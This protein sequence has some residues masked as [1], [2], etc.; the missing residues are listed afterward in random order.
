MTF[1]L[2][3]QNSGALPGG[4]G[5]VEMVGGALTIGRGEENDLT[6]PDPERM[7]SKRHC[8]IEDHGG[9]Y[10]VVDIS[11]NGT[12]LNYGPERLG[13]LPTPLNHGDVLQIG[14]Y[15]LVAEIASG[16]AAASA[17]P[18][19]GIAPPLEDGPVSH[20]QAV[21]HR[22]QHDFVGTLDDPA[23]KDGSDFLDGL[24]GS[25]DGAQASAGASSRQSWEQAVIPE[26]PLEA[27]A[28]LPDQEDPFFQKPEQDPFG[29]RGASEQDHSQSTADF[30]NKPKA[31]AELIP[32]DWDDLMAP[33]TPV[34]PA[35]P[36]A[37]LETG[38]PFAASS[39][40]ET[41]MADGPFAEKAPAEP[42]PSIAAPASA[43]EPVAPPTPDPVPMHVAP[44]TPAKP[45]PAPAANV[46]LVRTFL[47]EAGAGQL[48]IPDEELP[49]VMA[50]MG[51]V[52]GAMVTGMREI[53]ITRA[54]IKGELRMNRT[55]I[56]SAGN[57]PLKF[58]ISPEQAIEAMVRPST[59]GY[60]DAETATAEALRDIKAHEVAMM[61]GME[62]A[63]K[64]LLSRL[65][66]E[67]LTERI[68][69]GSSLGGLLGGKKA[70]YWEAYASMYSEIAKEAED[71][72][73]SAFGREFARA[74]EEQ[75]KKL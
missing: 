45:A 58:T 29:P 17:D 61:S 69:T 59:S 43:P 5:S 19:A 72:F 71:D 51:A 13:D 67:K 28:P 75:L 49:K 48:N 27:S 33:E 47:E 16:E 10:V 3:F 9:N 36:T 53:L 25:G 64:D 38:D 30:Y 68:E 14:N 37:Q 20:G 46:D 55:M 12:F 24:L 73:Q 39:V 1:R 32:D 15:E 54:S 63:L 18:L 40:G 31:Q 7:L 44:P 34:A 2:R 23:G 35:A 6:L 4:Q 42:Q 21:D 8:T 22:P 41:P 60:L 62:A 56:Q 11:T 52:F 57:N 74:Y 26:D 50:R 66:P 65:D 70:K